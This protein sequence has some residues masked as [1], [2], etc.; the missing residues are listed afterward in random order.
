MPVSSR[1]AGATAIAA[2]IAALLLMSLIVQASPA[3]AAQSDIDITK[4]APVAPAEFNGDLRD[5][6]K[7]A[8]IAPK[9]MVG[10]GKAGPVANKQ[11][12]PAPPIPKAATNMPAPIVSFAGLDHDTWGSGWPPD[13]VGDVGESFYVQAVNTSIGIFNK[14]GGPPVAAFTFNTLWSGTGT[15]CDDNNN[16]DPTVV[17]DQMADRYI[18]GDFAWT[19]IENGPY[20]ECIAVS[21]TGNPVTGGWWLYAYRADD[22]GHPWLPDYPKMGIWPD[23]LYMTANMFDCEDA[24]CSQAI[25][26]EPRVYAFNRDDMYAGAPLDS[27]V[28]DLNNEFV[29][30][31]LPSNLRGDPPPPAARTC[32]CRSRSRSSPSRCGSSTSTGRC[33]RARRSSARRTSLRRNTRSG[34][35]SSRAPATIST[36]SK[37]G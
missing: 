32:W 10:P 3:S 21:K 11:G 28:V 13:P 4:R 26:K 5:L 15:P 33:P 20:Y 18:V 29:F 7:P 14:T 22:A 23:G 1:I 25:Y 37:S 19:N 34:P 27:I 35:H 6:A 8:Q 16:G 36:R 31:L 17:Y 2:G 30:S 9:P 12:P 24:T